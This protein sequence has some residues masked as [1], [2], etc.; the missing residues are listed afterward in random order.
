MAVQS[1]LVTVR[2]RSCPIDRCDSIRVKAR[3]T[4][5]QISWIGIKVQPIHPADSRR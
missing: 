3:L 4:W 2:R 1:P 5:M